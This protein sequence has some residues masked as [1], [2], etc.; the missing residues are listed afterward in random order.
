MRIV[1]QRVSEAA[2]EVENKTVGQI[3]NGLLIFL[4]VAFGDTK[5]MIDKYIEKIARLRIFADS[6]GKTNLS[7]TDVKGG[8]LVVS[9]FTLCADCSKG[10]RPSFTG[11]ANPETARELYEYFILRCKDKFD[12]VAC[13]VFGAKM[14][15]K[16][17]NDGP[18]TILL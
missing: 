18:F 2:V 16:L 1:L 9:Q 17:T 3:G 4:G 12:E 11:A 10:N 7:V 14:S 8:V 15:V 13:G 6:E 5:E